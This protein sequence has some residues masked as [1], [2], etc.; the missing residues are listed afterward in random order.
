MD[1][2]TKS[3]VLFLYGSQTGAAKSICEGLF[4]QAQSGQGG[5]GIDALRLSRIA[6]LNDYVAVGFE[7]ALVCII[8]CSTTGDGD[9]PN[10]ADA[11]LRFIR[12]RTLP[13]DLYSGMHIAVLGLGDTNYDKFCNCSKQIV[14]RLSELGTIHLV[15]PSYAD[16]AVGLESIVD[17]WSSKL[18]PALRS[19]LV[20][21]GSGTGHGHNEIS[22]TQ[23]ATIA[24]TVSLPASLPFCTSTPLSSSRQHNN[25]VNINSRSS[26]PS[27]LTTS[28]SQQQQQHQSQSQSQHHVDHSSANPSDPFAFIAQQRAIESERRDA[29]EKVDEARRAV[30]ETG[31]AHQYLLPP[32]ALGELEGVESNNLVILHTH[33]HLAPSI[34]QQQQQQLGESTQQLNSASKGK[35]SRATSSAGSGLLSGSDSVIALHTAGRNQDEVLELAARVA[36]S[37]AQADEAARQEAVAA[38][39]AEK[40]FEQAELSQQAGINSVASSSS[41]TSYITNASPQTSIT[42]GV[43]SLAELFPSLVVPSLEESLKARPI[44]SVPQCNVAVKI[45]PALPANTFDLI[46][47][48][49][50]ENTQNVSTSTGNSNNIVVPHLG[51]SIESP[52]AATVSGARY[53]TRGGKSSERRVIHMDISVR[54]TPLEGAWQP[55]DSIAIITPNNASLCLGLCD[56]LGVAPNARLDISEL[57]SQAQEVTKTANGSMLNASP[58]TPL[59]PVS[60]TGPLS[61]TN[62]GSNSLKA[63]IS[64]C[65]VFIPTWLSGF[66]NPTILDLFLWCF[67]LTS[68][69]KKSFLRLM[70]EHCVINTNSDDT[71]NSST[72][73]EKKT[74]LFLASGAGKSHYARFIEDQR[75]TLLDLLLLFPSSRIPLAALISILP[76]LPPRSYSITCSPFSSRATLSVAFSA[77]EYECGVGVTVDDGQVT[78]TSGQM[79]ITENSKQ[80]QLHHRIKR[81]GLATS[82]MEHILCKDY[83]SNDTEHNEQTPKTV[84]SYTTST[85]TTSSL[86]RIILR[87]ARDFLPPVSLQSPLI[88]IGPGTGVAPFIGF[89]QHRAWRSEKLRSEALAVCRGQWRPGCHIQVA[90]SSSQGPLLGAS[91]LFFGNRRRDLDFL[92]EK[93]LGDFLASGSLTKLHTAWSRE[94]VTEGSNSPKAYVQTR[95]LEQSNLV[96]DLILRKAAHIYVC[97]DGMRMAKDVHAALCEALVIGSADWSEGKVESLSDAEAKLQALTKEAKYS[98]DVWS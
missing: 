2:S 39:A 80:E 11:F 18:W 72:L 94:V 45:L 44:P 1:S 70:A 84:S 19:F 16:E 81:V 29:R 88:M 60:N 78:N 96:A 27:Q 91:H 53:L 90:D 63:S 49:Q 21:S 26:S 23:V 9:A 34:A 37:I 93:E 62:V 73:I 6:P 43:R 7:S 66:P 5:S 89:L 86:V 46:V 57:Q 32:S 25:V 65:P 28:S 14:K 17:P 71:S 48:G 15:P 20:A 58:L 22:S 87:P 54:G 75:L 83:L 50:Q 47:L 24:A 98:K 67:D 40:K 85:T 77:V 55:G 95:I 41:S 97:G 31:D 52:L 59:S 82:Y 68:S 74:L 76:A 33:P 12:K 69:P 61:P 30:T 79:L 8:V 4:S 56:R 35:R 92:F 64:R 36:A 38:E 10:N 3:G 51:R 42:Q 13:K